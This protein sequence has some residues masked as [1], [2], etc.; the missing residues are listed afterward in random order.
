MLN[1][2]LELVKSMTATLTSFKEDPSLAARFKG[3][4]EEPSNP[5]P[6]YDPGVWPPPTPQEPRYQDKMWEVA[7]FPG[8]EFLSSAPG[9]KARNFGGL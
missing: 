1:K 5:S 4:A 7:S 3:R 9:N 2:E 6:G 8:S